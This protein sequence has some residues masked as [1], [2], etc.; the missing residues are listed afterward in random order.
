MRREMI[1]QE[2]DDIMN[3]PVAYDMIAIKDDRPFLRYCC[4]AIDQVR[5][6]IVQHNLLQRAIEASIPDTGML[7]LQCFNQICQ[8]MRGIVLRR[9]ERYPWDR[10]RR[11]RGPFCQQ[12][13]LAITGGGCNKRHWSPRALLQQ[14]KQTR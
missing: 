3:S 5:H 6:D 2:P 1:E 14:R 9:F 11:H 4:K 8:K 13:C 10:A 12:R 7:E